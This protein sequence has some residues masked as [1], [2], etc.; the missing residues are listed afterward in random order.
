LARAPRRGA[1]RRAQRGSIAAL[2]RRYYFL[3]GFIG[4]RIAGNDAYANRICQQH[5]Q[6]RRV[7]RDD[8]EF[9]FE[10]RRSASARRIR[11]VRLLFFLARIL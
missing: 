6:E 4:D 10:R 5:G 2:A 3:D 11:P 8:T 9:A 7:S 1:T